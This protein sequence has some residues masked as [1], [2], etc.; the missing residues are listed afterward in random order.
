MA[1]GD[2]IKT[3]SKSVG[4]CS[5][6]RRKGCARDLAHAQ[7]TFDCLGP[8]APVA[9]FGGVFNGV[10]EGYI[11]GVGQQEFFPMRVRPHQPVGS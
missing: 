6:A 10:P 3:R 4:G 11:Y 2:P 7:S 5:T 9:R 1:V 8:L